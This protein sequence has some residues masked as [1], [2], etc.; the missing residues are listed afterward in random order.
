M[1]DIQIIHDID[2]LFMVDGAEFTESGMPILQRARRRIMKN[3]VMPKCPYCHKEYKPQGMFR[4]DLSG[5]YGHYHSDTIK[6]T[7]ECGNDYFVSLQQRFIAR[8]NK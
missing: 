3:I 7:C 5:L 6:I 2:K 1:Y 4:N 8:K